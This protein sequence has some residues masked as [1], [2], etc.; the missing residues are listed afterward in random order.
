MAHN[1]NK[2]ITDRDTGAV[3]EKINPKI[4][5]VSHIISTFLFCFHQS[6]HISR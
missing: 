5:Y 6:Q 1:R 3:V 2:L 4:G